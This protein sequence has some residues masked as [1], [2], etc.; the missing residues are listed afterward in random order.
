MPK[1][2]DKKLK[3]KDKVRK[4]LDLPEEV[5]TKLTL[6]AVQS[7]HKNFKRYAENLLEEDAEKADKKEEK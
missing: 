2:K 7:P 6:K 5:V 3:Q 4:N 1:K